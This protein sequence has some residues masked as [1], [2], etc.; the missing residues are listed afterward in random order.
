MDINILRKRSCRQMGKSNSNSKL[1]NSIEEK[2]Q[3]KN[4]LKVISNSSVT[5][6]K[7]VEILSEEPF[8]TVTGLSQN[9]AS[10]DTT[11]NKK[12]M[13][14]LFKMNLGMLDPLKDQKISNNSSANTNSVKP[15]VPTENPSLNSHQK[16]PEVETID[17]IRNEV[18]SIKNFPA[19]KRLNSSSSVSDSGI[20]KTPV[21]VPRFYSPKRN[22]SEPQNEN[23]N[24]IITIDDDD[25]D[26][27][28]CNEKKEMHID[29]SV[30]TGKNFNKIIS[31]TTINSKQLTMKSSK[32]NQS[33]IESQG[34][35]SQSPS[36]TTVNLSYN[37]RSPVVSLNSQ[38][39]P[40]KVETVN[41]EG[42]TKTISETPSKT[43][44]TTS[45]VSS[46]GTSGTSSLKRPNSAK[47]NKKLVR[48][49]DDIT[50]NHVKQTSDGATQEKLSTKEKEESKKKKS[51]KGKVVDKVQK[52]I[53][54]VETANLSSK[55]TPKKM[56]KAPVKT[57]TKSKSPKSPEFVDVDE[58][59]S[60][61]ETLANLIRKVHNK[62]EKGEPQ[63]KRTLSGSK[64]MKT[65]IK[66][67]KLSQSPIKKGGSKAEVKNEDKN[68]EQ[69]S[70]KLLKKENQQKSISK[71]SL[72]SEKNILKKDK[73]KQEQKG[74]AKQESKGKTSKNNRNKIIESNAGN[75]NQAINYDSD[76]SENDGNMPV[77]KDP[78]TILSP[79]H[80]PLDSSLATLLDD[81][82]KQKQ[83][84]KQ[85][86][87]PP[88]PPQKKRGRKKLE[89]GQKTRKKRGRKRIKKEVVEEA[90]NLEKPWGTEDEEDDEEDEEI[91]GDVKKRKTRKRSQR[92]TG[93][94]FSVTGN[95]YIA[96]G[97]L[98]DIISLLED[99]E[100]IEGW[101][102]RD[103]SK[104]WQK[105]N[106]SLVY[107]GRQTFK[108]L[109]EFSEEIALLTKRFLN[110]PHSTKRRIGALYTLYGLYYKFPLGKLRFF[111]LRFE[112]GEYEDLLALIFPFRS[113][114][115]NPDPAY[116]FRKLEL[117]GAILH[118][119]SAIEPCYD[120][121]NEERDH[122]E[123]EYGKERLAKSSAV[124]NAVPKMQLQA[125]L[126]LLQHYH[127]LKAKIAGRNHFTPKY[128]MAV[129]YIVKMFQKRHYQ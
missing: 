32:Q 84:Q 112:Y 39:S 73:P 118:C 96:S 17:I 110:P 54:T 126:N 80:V 64:K 34:I 123:L 63:R 4:N 15:S 108:E 129:P 48:F 31:K 52:T 7:D 56:R 120:F 115:D 109:L 40:S 27:Q 58:N 74:K 91:T 127:S 23:F 45:S 94:R 3:R 42:H 86:P 25:D 99:F 43:H 103:F 106:F 50:S 72:A 9:V 75:E 51:P 14:T 33:L 83:Q 77:V 1:E 76:I 26:V 116:I 125:D 102:F 98:N 37:N 78:A 57:P 124:I 61:H 101:R 128:R 18:N 24:T 21:K 119:A 66:E 47:A 122:V 20:E 114:V 100:N 38:P 22:N 28:L 36:S 62:E 107:R 111:H 104:C 55:Q 117:E 11:V 13:V 41:I 90:V 113:N 65:N 29:A 79:K 89:D 60:D 70:K 19:K 121:H 88:P 81:Q 16:T 6:E 69:T 105:K 97:Y 12:V 35:D 82:Q 46:V 5:K 10:G 8:K 71:K 2:R 44:T 93:R 53:S 49:G 87:T 95:W 85:P 30:K 59:S 92:R 67:R 68:K